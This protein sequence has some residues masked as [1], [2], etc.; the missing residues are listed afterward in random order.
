VHASIALAFKVND[1][2][3][4]TEQER[5]ANW[6]VVVAATVKEVLMS[7]SLTSTYYSVNDD[8]RVQGALVRPLDL[9]NSSS[10]WYGAANRSTWADAL[11]TL[12]TKNQSTFSNSSLAAERKRYLQEVDDSVV[13]VEASFN[14]LGSLEA[15]GGS[16]GTFQLAATSAIETSMDDGSFSVALLDYCECSGNTTMKSAEE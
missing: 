16:A 13:L 3:S 2:S 15:V 8:V 5:L 6:A 1:L 11:D 7:S 4:S 12:T 14:L 9:S 10:Q